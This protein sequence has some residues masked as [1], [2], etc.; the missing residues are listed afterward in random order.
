MFDQGD[1]SYCHTVTNTQP[2]SHIVACDPPLASM[3]P[4]FIEPNSV[5]VGPAAGEQSWERQREI[6]KSDSMQIDSYLFIAQAICKSSLLSLVILFHKGWR[7]IPA[8]AT[9]TIHSR[10]PAAPYGS[11][12]LRR[13][14]R[15]VFPR[16]D[17]VMKSWCNA[18][19]LKETGSSIEP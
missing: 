18:L 5:L 12:P 8:A 9:F 17:M 15:L 10:S 7:Q 16:I 6:D 3:S 2:R 11:G 4:L 14:A 1:E 13:R 19:K